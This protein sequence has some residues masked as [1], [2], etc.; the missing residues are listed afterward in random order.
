MKPRIAESG[1]GKRGIKHLPS[2]TL[3]GRRFGRW[4]MNYI[5]EPGFP[6]CWRERLILYCFN[7][8]LFST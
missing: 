8:W 7:V 3:N 5:S 1:E 4:L 6:V 2:K